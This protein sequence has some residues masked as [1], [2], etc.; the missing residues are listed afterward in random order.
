VKCRWVK[1]LEVRELVMVMMLRLKLE[2]HVNATKW[3]MREKQ[4]PR[5]DAGIWARG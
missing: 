5:H 2:K 4:M 1:A 3:S